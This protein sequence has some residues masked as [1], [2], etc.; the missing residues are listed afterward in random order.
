MEPPQSKPTAPDALAAAGALLHEP[1][2]AKVR[3]LIEYWISVH[4]AGLLP[5]RRHFD[6]LDVPTLLQNIWMIDV[7]RASELRLRYRLIGTSVARA[8]E[9]D[10]TGQYLHDAHPDFHETPVWSYMREV[11]DTGMPNWRKGAPHFGMRQGFRHL[12]RVFLPMAS[13]GRTVDLI[14][15]LTVFLDSQGNEF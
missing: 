5:G 11:A 4:P 8:F 7:E 1:L 10:T 3:A 15:A 6:P 14:L 2:H 12:E 13:D 9:K